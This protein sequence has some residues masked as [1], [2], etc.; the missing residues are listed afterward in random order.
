VVGNLQ[1]VPRR[2]RRLRRRPAAIR[3]AADAWRKHIFDSL[4]LIAPLA[5]LPEGST[6]IDVG[7][8]GG[9]R[10]AEEAEVPLLA[11]L[12]MELSVVKGGDSGRPVVLA[13]PQSASAAAFRALAQ[14]LSTRCAL[15]PLPA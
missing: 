13:A 14:E 15:R 6:L 10:L 9:L 3:D 1:G 12:P 7:S 11:Q 5:E 2:R 4:T 8:G